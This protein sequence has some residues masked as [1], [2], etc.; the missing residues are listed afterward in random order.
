MHGKHELLLS[1]CDAQY[2]T[3]KSVK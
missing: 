2:E 3:I 1:Y